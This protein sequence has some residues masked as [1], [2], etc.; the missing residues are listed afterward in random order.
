MGN[1]YSR[2]TSKWARLTPVAKEA[3]VLSVIPD[4]AVFAVFTRG[5]PCVLAVMRGL[6]TVVKRL[7]VMM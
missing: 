5:A 4:I 1:Y 6:R 2:V 7:A 3:I